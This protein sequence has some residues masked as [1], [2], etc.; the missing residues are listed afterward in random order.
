VTP[1]TPWTDIRALSWPTV[2]AGQQFCFDVTVS[3]T[4][5][6]G[7]EDWALDL[8]VAQRPFNG[9]T[10]GY[11]VQGADAGKVRLASAPVGG[12][13]TIVGT[14]SYRKLRSSDPALSFRVCHWGTP[15]PAYDAALTYLVSQGPV[16]GDPNGACVATTVAVTG[17]PVFY[18]GWRADVDMTAAIAL[19]SSGGNSFDGVYANDGYTIEVLPGNVYRVSGAH[20]GNYGLRDG[21]TRTVVLCAH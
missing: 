4:N 17:T 14:G 16:T 9:A 5:A 12:I 2:V 15:V 11:Q 13:L 3:T 10:S 1:G 18:A 8:D 7:Q 21:M 20:W 6:S 19:A